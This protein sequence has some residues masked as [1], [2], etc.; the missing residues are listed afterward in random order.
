MAQTQKY[1]SI[2]MRQLNATL[3]TTKELDSKDLRK[4]S[5]AFK[6]GDYKQ[7]ESGAGISLKSTFGIADAK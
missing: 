7:D 5:V 1:T 3:K 4:F 6:I 2:A